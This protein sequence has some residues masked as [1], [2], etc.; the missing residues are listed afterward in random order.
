MYRK[1]LNA[2][3]PLRILDRTLHGGL[4]KG[5]VGVV[6]A[7]AGVGKT[8]CLIQ[9]GLDALLREQQLMHIAIGQSVEHVSAWYDALFNDLAQLNLLDDRDAIRA[10]AQRNSVIKAFP[11]GGFSLARF[12]EALALFETHM[13]FKPAAF[14]IDGFDWS[15]P[16]AAGFIAEIRERAAKLGAEAWLTAQTSR[17]FQFKASPDLAPPCDKVAKHIDV[18][19]FLEPLGSHVAVRVM[20]D[21]DSIP[22]TDSQLELHSDTMR[23]VAAGG[24]VGPRKI[25][26][27]SFMLLSGGAN[28]AEAEFGAAAERHG[29]CETNF[30][31][32]GHAPARTRGLMQLTDDELKAGDISSTYLKAHMRRTYPETPTFKKVLQSIWHQVN[33]AGEVFSIGQIKADKTVNGGTG[34]AVE[35][36]KH[37]N[38][39]VFVYDQ[40]RRGWFTWKDQDWVAIAP[41]KITR[42]RFAGTGTRFLSDDGRDAIHELFDRS[43]ETR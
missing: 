35:L 10:Q 6:M 17:G 13:N 4:G 19:L 30:T 15:D 24:A 41:P 16:G 23:L 27:A 26:A 25:P 37:W 7:P 1:E 42:E 2:Q 5:H 8:A 9:I 36:A 29:L 11:T 43:F 31:F 18:A 28:G 40:E 34:W 33:T 21:H 22:P 20:K 38:K 14:L 39:P 3:S 32:S 12:D